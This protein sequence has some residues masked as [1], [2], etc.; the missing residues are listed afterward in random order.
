AQ[1]RALD[2]PGEEQAA[3]LRSMRS[4]LAEFNVYAWAGRMLIDAA[5]LRRQ[6]RLATHLSAA[7]LAA[8]PGVEAAAPR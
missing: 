5:R 2:M 3:R 8:Q 6:T 1:A 4:Y 7:N